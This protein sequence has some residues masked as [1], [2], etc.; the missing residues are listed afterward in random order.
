MKKILPLIIICIFVIGGILYLKKDTT[1]VVIDIDNPSNATSSIDIRSEVDIFISNNRY[2]YSAFTSLLQDIEFSHDKPNLINV[3]ESLL[4]FMCRKSKDVFQSL[5]RDQNSFDIGVLRKQFKEIMKRC[6]DCDL[7][8]QVRYLNHC[9][10]VLNE[11]NGASFEVGI[12]LNR[13]RDYGEIDRFKNKLR[14]STTIEGPE[15]IEDLKNDFEQDL[16]DFEEKV[17]E[18]NKNYVFYKRYNYVLPNG[19]RRG[20]NKNKILDRNHFLTYK[21]YLALGDST[22]G[23]KGNYLWK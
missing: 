16:I 5:C 8:F 3:H 9:L 23:G 21:Y 11:E 15:K 17:D 10:W 4:L 1:P 20:H 7:Q 12:I 19:V 2:N 18:W 22:I 14:F 6:S 13:E